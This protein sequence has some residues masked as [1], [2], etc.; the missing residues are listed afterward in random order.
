MVRGLFLKANLNRGWGVR[1]CSQP[2]GESEASLLFG[3]SH[4]V[5][6]VES[7]EYLQIK[8]DTK[9]N[10]FIMSA[11]LVKINKDLFLIQDAVLKF[12]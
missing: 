10:G 8:I 11:F 5:V 2:K 3:F 12:C 9:T 6:P 1:F 4:D 7:D